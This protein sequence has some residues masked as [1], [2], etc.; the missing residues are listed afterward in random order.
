MPNLIK[1]LT[2]DY[3]NSYF[4]GSS[5]K[6]NGAVLRIV[7]ANNSEVFTEDVS[8]GNAVM[9][10]N[11]F[12]TGFAVFSYPLLGYRRFGDD[13][14]G[15]M[16]KKQ[17]VHR[18]LRAANIAVQWSAATRLLVDLGAVPL[19]RL[20]D[21][22]K[23]T[24]AFI[25]KFDTLQDVPDLL[26]GNKTGL[27]LSENILIEPSTE[28]EDEWYTVFFKQAAVG[29]LDS[30][31]AVTWTSDQHDHLLPALPRGVTRG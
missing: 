5:I 10:P 20:S 19:T 15:Y 26:A 27:V 28:A 13:R 17:S 4:N 24:A 1:N 2:R 8:T 29:K 23:V 18:G 6:Y 21:A 30:K 12:F 31:G 16:T 25:P 9:V 22:D 14:I 3:F 11:D 7:E